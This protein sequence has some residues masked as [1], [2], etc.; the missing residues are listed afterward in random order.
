[1]KTTKFQNNFIFNN[2]DSSLNEK[3]KTTPSLLF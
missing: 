3:D 2:I 1:M